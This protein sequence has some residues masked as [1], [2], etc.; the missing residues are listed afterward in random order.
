MVNHRSWEQNQ[1]RCFCRNNKE[2]EKKI[3]TITD[4]MEQIEAEVNLSGPNQVRYHFE[5]VHV[6][7]C[8]H[9]ILLTQF[10]IVLK[11]KVKVQV[12]AE[13]SVKGQHIAKSSHNVKE[14]FS[15]NTAK[16][17]FQF[18]RAFLEKKQRRYRNCCQKKLRG[19]IISGGCS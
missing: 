12:K 15:P 8:E 19:S 1:Y 16:G 6:R 2:E 17:S 18:P 9:K 11:I 14:L 10:K 7:S 3:G 5:I 13:V 4:K